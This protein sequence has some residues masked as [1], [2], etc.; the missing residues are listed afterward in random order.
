MNVCNSCSVTYEPY[1]Q[2]H[3]ICRPCKR[4][5]DRQFHANRSTVVRDRK[6]RLQK[7]LRAVSAQYVYDYFRANPCTCCGESRI[8]CLQFDH[9]QGE[10]LGNVSH[11]V[12]SS[13]LVKIKE[14][15]L[16][17]RVLCANCHAIRTA[18]QFD[19]Y[20]NVVK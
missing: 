11:M 6:L 19:W 8:P 3:K 15:I 10:K 2:K 18:E 20:A 14:E 17:C 4:I 16:K 1:G 9:Y 12:N 7:E 13:S 5:Y